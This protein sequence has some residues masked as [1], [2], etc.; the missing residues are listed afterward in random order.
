QALDT[1]SRSMPH[2]S[3]ANL[4]LTKNIR[5]GQKQNIR[6]FGSVNNLFDKRNVNWVYPKTGKPDDTG[7]DISEPNSNYT[8]DEVR[9]NYTQYIKDP[10]AYSSG[11]TYSFGI[12]YNW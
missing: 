10:S 9:H 5:L 11:R 12:S 2:T 1:N 6:L 8:F 4:R 3:S 7:E